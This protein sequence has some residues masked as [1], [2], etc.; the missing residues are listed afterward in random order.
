MLCFVNSFAKGKPGFYR[1]GMRYYL[2]MD[3]GGSHTRS[4][5][6]GEDGRILGTGKSGAANF[7]NVG[8]DAAGA[9]LLE[10]RNAAC[11]AAG[12]DPVPAAHAFLGCA[13]VKSR[14]SIFAMRGV[15]EAMGLA[16]A[17]EVTVENDLANALTGGLSGR[18]GI[19]L[20]AGTGSNCLGRNQA[21][22]S[23]MCGGWGWL[24]DDAG[25]AFGLALDAVKTAARSADGREEETSL[26]P[27]ALAFFGLS[28]ANELLEQFYIREWTQSGVAEFAPVVVRRAEEGD[29]VARRL[30][31][32]HA[33][34]LAELVAGVAR[35]LD[36]PGG[37]EVVILGSC[38]RSGPPYQPLIEAQIRSLCPQAR[39]VEPEGSTLEGA[40]LNALRAGGHPGVPLIPQHTNSK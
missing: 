28:E 10:A 27:A 18:P 17:G 30:L 22:Q 20:I 23:F 24:L 5:L 2:G 15:A 31:D 9:R 21:G 11:Q 34:A 33:L 40:G 6:V 38:A 7:H 26:L 14:E 39:I 12:L 36:F 1:W 3:V 35:Q 4:I 19:A 25:G 32:R 37:P 8:V 29:P 16:A 13:G